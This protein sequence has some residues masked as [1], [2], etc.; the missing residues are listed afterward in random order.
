M[1]TDNLPAEIRNVVL[2]GHSNSGKTTLVEAL[3]AQTG[4]IQ[5]AGS[6]EAGTTA[7]DFDEVEI[8]HQRSVNLSLLAFDY[9]GSTGKVR[10][11]LL[12]TVFL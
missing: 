10:I 7:S 2:I 9:P 12:D 3:L 11:N 1:A 5:R 4:A 6:V 8:A